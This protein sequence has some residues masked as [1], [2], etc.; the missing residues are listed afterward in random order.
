MVEAEHTIY[1]QGSRRRW[2][3]F[4]GAAICVLAALAAWQIM[5]MPRV[6]AVTPGPDAFVNDPSPA[7]V[8]NV[9]RL[10]KLRDVRMTFDGSDVTHVATRSGDKL[11]FIASGLADGD[12]RVTFSAASRNLLRRDVRADWRFTVDT[13]APTLELDSSVDQ[14]R[15]NSSPATFSGSTEPHA[16][17]TVTGGVVKASAV[18]GADGKFAVTAQLPDGPST[19]AIGIVDRASNSTAE[20]LDVYVDAVPPVLTVTPLPETVHSA[21]I[22]M[23]I[24]ASDQLGFPKVTVVLD[25]EER[26]AKKQASG[27]VFKASSLAQ[28]RHMVAVC[29][30]DKG[31]NVVADWQTFVVDSTERFGSEAMWWG[32]LGKDVRA[33][34]KRLANAGVFSGTHNGVYDS[35]T[36]AAVRSYQNKHGL[37]ADGR[38]DGVTLTALGGRII[39]DLGDLHLYLYRGD[40]LYKSYGIAVGQATY[41][42]P[43]GSFVI[44]NKQ[45]DP[46]WVPPDSDWAKGA[47]PIP[48]GPNNPLGTRWIGTSYPGVGIHGTP[49]DASIGTYA[50]HGCIRMHIP[51]VEDLYPRVVIGMPV[52]I[53]L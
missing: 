25:G 44:V 6:S 17:V 47:K 11:T 31:G 5:G 41:P 28:G 13:N 42:T 32:A 48:P 40:K 50:S 18:S 19:V 35:R 29:V 8:L 10:E 23:H 9:K 39:I 49:D 4:A 46:T 34:Q 38:V 27:M 2:L 33:L 21:K 1:G 15:V 30:S 52:I 3:Y 20:T 14:G 12:H 24:E 22:E 51:D 43:T 37:T 53:R 45:V 26:R 7:I 16:T 36:E